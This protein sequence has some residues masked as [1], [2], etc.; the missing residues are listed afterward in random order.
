MVTLPQT[1]AVAE[2]FPDVDE[3]IALDTNLLRSPRTLFRRATLSELQSSIR[4]IRANRFDLAVSLYGQT[5][6]LVALLSR[7]SKRVGYGDEAYR[8]SLDIAAPYGRRS[9]PIRQHDTEYS[10][11]LVRA[12]ID[13]GSAHSMDLPRI[14]VDQRAFESIEDM[15]NKVGVSSDDVLVVMHAGSGYGDY[16]RWPV[17]SFAE[18]ANRLAEVGAKSVVLGTESERVI[19]ERIQGTSR[20]VSFAGKTTVGELMALLE[21]AD[22]VVSG[23]SGPLHLAAALGTPAVAIYGPTDPEVNGPISWRQQRVIILRHDIACSPCYS[24]RTRDECPL[25][26]PICM[27]LV[28]VEQVFSAAHAILGSVL[29]QSRTPKCS[30][31]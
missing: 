7:A 15:L 16:K 6:S 1:S 26:D 13:V 12:A 25:G 19:A 9:N 2:S 18:L 21:R 29:T 5:A 27:R 14:E 3:V 24:V 31:T 17:H 11:Q 10:R 4:R 20:A 30:K 8:G 23:D 28:S 22:L